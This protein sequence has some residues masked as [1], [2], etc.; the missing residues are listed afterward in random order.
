MPLTNRCTTKI[1]TPFGALMPPRSSGGSRV[2]A[3]CVD[4]WEPALTP[5]W[6]SGESGDSQ[7]LAEPIELVSREIV[8]HDPAASVRPGDDLYPRAQPPRDRFLEGSELRAEAELAPRRRSMLLG[9]PG[10]EALGVADRKVPGDHVR[11]RLDL[12]DWIGDG[13]KRPGVRGRDPLL[14]Q[15]S[16]DLDCRLQQPDRVRDR[17]SAASQLLGNRFLGHSELVAQPGEGAGLVER[18]EVTPLEVLY[19]GHLE[20]SAV[21][22]H[23][24]KDG[25][26]GSEPGN[27][28]GAQSALPGHQVEAG[29]GRLNHQ[30]LK[31]AVFD[32]R[33]SQLAEGVLVELGT[34]LK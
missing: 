17:R 22:D 1:M 3:P 33:S 5:P 13:Q 29:V 16:L 18:R 25:R 21:P 12:K 8:D 4:C 11:Q 7:S 2:G 34:G 23:W 20:A 30:G 28:S 27:L 9:D 26:H 24:P 32:D 19:Q 31:D 15:R 6:P 10:C 14:G